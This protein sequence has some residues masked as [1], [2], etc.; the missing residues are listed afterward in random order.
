MRIGIVSRIDEDEALELAK[1]ILSEFS[2]EDLV[3]APGV[4]REFGEGG[5]PIEDMEVDS[6]VTVGGDGTVLYTLQE[7]SDAPILGINMGDRGFLAD[8]GPTEALEAVGKMVEGELE[9]TTKERL[10]VEISGRWVADAL[11]EGVIRSEDPTKVLSFKVLVDGEE[12]ESARGDGLIVATPTGST[13]YALAAGGP[14]I[15]P[16]VEA[17]VAVPICTHRPKAMPLVFPMSSELEV[18]LLGSEE[19]AIVSVDGQVAEKVEDG[20]VVNFKRSKREA[21]FYEWRSKFY[22]RMREKL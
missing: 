8:V 21:K 7:T 16:E 18:E 13:A 20:A 14:I 9:L 2:E 15:D 4:A 1:R 5:V 22:G 11:N 10:S 12:A 6:I 17:N 19:N 3:L